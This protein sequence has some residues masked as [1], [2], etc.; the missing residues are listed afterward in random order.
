MS[1][2]LRE[3]EAEHRAEVEMKEDIV[4]LGTYGKTLTVLFTDEAIEDDESEDD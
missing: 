1:D 2:R 3:R 4:G